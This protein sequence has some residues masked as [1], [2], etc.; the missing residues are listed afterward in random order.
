[1]CCTKRRDRAWV[2]GKVPEGVGVGVGDTEARR[3]MV[4]GWASVP[5][6][7]NQVAPNLSGPGTKLL[8]SPTM[9]A[10]MIKSWGS[11]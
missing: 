6:S 5:L 9:Y 1:M 2:T 11:F 8:Q 10:S 4:G 3:T 7:E